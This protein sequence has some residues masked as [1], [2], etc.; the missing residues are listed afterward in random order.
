MIELGTMP[1][2]INC[3]CVG[4]VFGDPIWSKVFKPD[5]IKT[6]SE[7]SI[8]L[9]LT[10]HCGISD[11]NLVITDWCMADVV[12]R[13]AKGIPVVDITDLA[14]EIGLPAAI[15][16]CYGPKLDDWVRDKLTARN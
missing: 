6:F 1:P 3:F 11:D 13:Q 4:L 7:P 5:F 9:G 16:T 10:L 8:G 2:Q 15:E 12:I 14:N